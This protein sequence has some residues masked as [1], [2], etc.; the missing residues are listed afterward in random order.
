MTTVLLTGATGFVGGAT[1]AR[2]LRDE[3]V[4]RLLVLVRAT[5]LEHAGV[6]LCKS[7]AR[8]G[9]E[10]LSRIEILRGDLERCLL[11]K[12]VLRKL[13]HVL[14]AAA[15]TSLRSRRTVWS[16][17]VEG[18]QTLANVVTRAPKLERFLFVG[19]AYRCGAL[20]ESVVGE[21]D[22][23]A[24]THVAEYTRT[25]AEAEQL[26]ERM[27]LPLVIARPSI[28]VGHTRLGV[29]PSASLYA[30]TERS[31][32]RACRHSLTPGGGTSSRWIGLRKLSPICCSGDRHGST[33]SLRSR[34][35]C[36][37]P[38]CSSARPPCRPS[39]W[40]GRRTS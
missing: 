32:G 38:P 4:E 1:A 3:R 6:Q 26:L 33:C 28:V 17:N 22:L 10:P 23:A 20:S 40:R 27:A 12:E 39:R 34:S 9:V 19:T 36:G 35:G 21:D 8:F 31:R 2:L 14:H 29:A 25:K 16:A 18:T 5:G 37:C 11:S 13:T 7:L 15:H 30:I 24:E